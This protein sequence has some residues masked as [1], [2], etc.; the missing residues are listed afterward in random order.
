MTLEDGWPED[1]DEEAYDFATPR[2][3]STQADVEPADA[4]R[5]SELD[6]RDERSSSQENEAIQ[7]AISSLN[8]MQV[9]QR[10][11]TG[12]SQP[13]KGPGSSA[14]FHHM[15]GKCNKGAEC[16]FSHGKGD[17]AELVTKN[18]KRKLCEK[19][20]VGYYHQLNSGRYYQRR[21][22]AYPPKSECNSGWNTHLHGS[23]FSFEAKQFVQDAR[24]PII[25]ADTPLRVD[26]AGT[27]V[28][29]HLTACAVLHVDAT[30]PMTK[31]RTLFEVRAYVLNMAKG[32]VILGVDAIASH[33]IPLTTELL[34]FTREDVTAAALKRKLSATKLT[35]EHKILWDYRWDNN[36]RTLE[37]EMKTQKD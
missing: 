30:S 27:G 33:L 36:W 37:S 22:H 32:D 16:T 26:L 28:I 29:R 31:A 10:A 14:C 20:R 18:A 11:Q 23:G 21:R 25:R 5:E 9:Q 19:L 17:A 35:V 8:A 6:A 34:M 12:A 1:S 7:E 2:N 3:G 24:I 13:G 15:I 4:D